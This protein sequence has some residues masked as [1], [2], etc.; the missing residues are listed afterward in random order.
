MTEPLTS[1]VPYPPPP[2]ATH[3]RAWIQPYL[4]DVRSL[5]L[6]AGFTPVSIAGRALGALALVEYVTPSPLTYGE[7]AWMPCAVRATAGGGTRRGY[8]V[9]KMYV[10]SPASLAAGRTEWALPKQ[11]ARFE[12]ED[13]RAVVD[14]EDGAHLVL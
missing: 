11:L 13:D 5:A 10:D 3:G 12:F 9:E 14:T 2:W 6:P 8:Y 7:L 1:A 4:V